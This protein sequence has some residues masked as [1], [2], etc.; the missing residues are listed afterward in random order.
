MHFSNNNPVVFFLEMFLKI[1]THREQDVLFF[2]LNQYFILHSLKKP[3][4]IY[5]QCSILLCKS[6]N[7]LVL[8]SS[9]GT[10]S[11]NC[12]IT[13]MLS[14]NDV[15]YVM[16]LFQLISL[17]HVRAILLTCTKVNCW[18]LSETAAHVMWLAMMILIVRETWSAVDCV[19]TNVFIHK[20]FILLSI[21]N[22]Q[23]FKQCIVCDLLFSLCDLQCIIIIIMVAAAAAAA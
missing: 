17:V 6:L 4:K 13:Y 1:F 2:F 20:V 7:I 16:L 14:S 12:F 5:P 18:N 19:A 21:L 9:W 22:F 11:I 15:T 3:Y 8:I 23:C 10:Y